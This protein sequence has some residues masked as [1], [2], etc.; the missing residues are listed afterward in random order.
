MTLK[1]VWAGYPGGYQSTARG[2]TPLGKALPFRQPTDP[3]D[4]RS[5]L[6]ALG[7]REYWYPA[8]P[9]KD[10]KKQPVV[11]RMLGDDIVF[12]RGKDGQVKALL[13][14]CPHRGAFL[15][16][17]DCF[18][19]GFITCPYH[20]ATFDG[21]GNCVAMLTEGPDSKAVG[22]MKAWAF[23]TVTLKGIVFAWT[24]KGDPIDPREDIPPEMFDEPHTI[25]RWSC[26]VF[27]CN[28]ILV[29]ENTN[30][31]HNAFYVHRNC[32]EVLQSRLG[33]RPRTPLGYRTKVINNKTA[34][35]NA[36]SNGIAP[37]ERYYFDEEGKIPY[38]MYYPGVDGVWPI[39]RWRLLWTSYF[40]K[41]AAARRNRI[42]QDGLVDP[43]RQGGAPGMRVGNGDDDWQGTRLPSISAKGTGG[44][45]GFRSHRWAVPVEGDVTRIVYVNIERYAEK[46]S[47]LTRMYKGF[48]WPYRNWIHNFNFRWADVD[49]ERTCRY[50]VPEYLTPTDSTV[51]VIR[52]VLLEYARGV[53][54]AEELKEMEAKGVREE[55]LVDRLNAEIAVSGSSAHSDEIKEGLAKFGVPVSTEGAGGAGGAGGA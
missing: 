48:T 41:R 55:Q 18:Y 8:L 52:K 22:Q 38:Q 33:G 27:P 13:D 30:D 40:E 11:L 54:T 12:F 53:H 9:D 26:Q 1:R 14:V 3:N 51:V 28:W 43:Q 29:L 31:A 10:V 21:D 39:N 19:D 37:T 15:S 4:I 24:G 44:R 2:S 49:A 34:N 45:S 25:V 7:H 47:T 23:P 6:P 50:D 35:Y 42:R 17:G 16:L 20:G 46:P 5:K 32:I 36:G